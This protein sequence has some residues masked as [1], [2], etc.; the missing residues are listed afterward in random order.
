MMKNQSHII[1]QIVAL[2]KQLEVDK[3]MSSEAEPVEAQ[4]PLR[5]KKKTK[6]S[7]YQ[8]LIDKRLAR[9]KK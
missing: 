9:I 1:K 6:A 2:V 7:D 8:W 5:G 3:N 4:P